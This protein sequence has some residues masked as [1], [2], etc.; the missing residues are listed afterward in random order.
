M[1]C[2]SFTGFII[3]SCLFG[4]GFLS[5]FALHFI[6]LLRIGLVN[7]LELGT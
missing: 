7:K 1:A 2:M 5:V 4:G 3:V 6:Y